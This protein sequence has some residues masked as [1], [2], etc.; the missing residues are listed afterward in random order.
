M[1]WVKRTTARENAIE[2]GRQA[3]RAGEKAANTML[4][5]IDPTLR[6]WFYRGYDLEQ[7]KRNRA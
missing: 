3:Y 7:M 2:L 1:D 5:S 6:D 4:A